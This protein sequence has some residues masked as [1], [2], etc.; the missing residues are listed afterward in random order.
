MQT[1]SGVTGERFFK[2]TQKGKFLTNDLL[3][4]EA[5]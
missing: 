4:D 5:E 3:S 2:I 1:E